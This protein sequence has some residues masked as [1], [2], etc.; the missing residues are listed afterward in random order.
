MA[1]MPLPSN[2]IINITSD[3]FN[4]T[5]LRTHSESFKITTLQVKKN[6]KNKLI[7]LH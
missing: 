2:I 6:I 3:W 7:T 4:A 1:A 5:Q